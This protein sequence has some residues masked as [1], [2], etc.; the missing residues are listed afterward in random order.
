MA[1]HREM[2]RPEK[3]AY[4]EMPSLKGKVA[5]V[6]GANSREG[7]GY[8]VA[9]QL[10]RKGARVYISARS[11]EKADGA[12]ASMLKEDDPVDT[13]L[14]KPLV[15]DLLDFPSI[16]RAA[17]SI[18]KDEKRLD[19][20]VNNA[21]LLP[22]RMEFE[23]NGISTSFVTNYLGQFLFTTE[24]VPL[25][26]A[27]A[28]LD[29]KYG[30]R[31]INVGSTAHY[32]CPTSAKFGSLEDFNNQFNGR[33]DPMSIY[34]HYGY[35]KLASLLFTRELQRKFD[36]EGTPVL[37]MAPH[38]G[39]VGTDGAARYQG[40]RDNEAFRTA[41]KPAE[42]ALTVLFAAA[43]PEPAL[44][45]TKY[46]GAFLLPFGGWKLDSEMARDKK[47]AEELWT[48]SEKLLES[49]LSK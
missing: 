17:R 28:E 24:L 47:L 38:P 32:D 48:A 29:P 26:K 46:R 2:A 34:W 10:A 33:D 19:I 9:Y 31:V 12:I 40:T 5:I 39:G 16:Q 45:S 8:H 20:L 22:G 6:T 44:E 15:M 35:T 4:D 37:C 11:A 18:L 27:A 21:A 3:W 36:A 14:L 41:Y 25:I 43:H 7:M 30:V 1:H 42:G 13:A 49:I 23:K